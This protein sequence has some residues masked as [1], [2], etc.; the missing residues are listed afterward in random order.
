MTES[1]L[2]RFEKLKVG[3]PDST[4]AKTLRGWILSSGTLVW[5]SSCSAVQASFKEKGHLFNSSMCGV[6]QGLRPCG[7]PLA[8]EQDFTVLYSPSHCWQPVVPID[9][10]GFTSGVCMQCF[11]FTALGLL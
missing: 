4:H 10:N 7:R 9:D 3:K 6:Q 8:L 2:R 11:G 1:T 5:R